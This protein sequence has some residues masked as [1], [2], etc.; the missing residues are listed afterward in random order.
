MNA[1]EDRLYDAFVGLADVCVTAG[2]SEA[3][4][5][6]AQMQGD[7]WRL[8]GDGRRFR[9]IPAP[10]GAGDVLATGGGVR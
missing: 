4:F 1:Y 9:S 8:E 6:R 7:M 3:G 10:A 5:M 2:L